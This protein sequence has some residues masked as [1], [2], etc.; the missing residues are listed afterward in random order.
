MQI[1]VNKGGRQ[2]GPYTVE[3]LRE[4]I[5]QGSFSPHDLACFDGQNWV[6]VTDVPGLTLGSQLPMPP[7]APLSSAPKKIVLWSSIGGITALLAISLVVWF[8]A[9]SGKDL[10]LFYF[11]D[12]V[13]VN[14]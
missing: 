6:K 13:H 10:D 12:N 1:Y 8:L 11:V 2:Y 14:D 9:I 4:Y 7:P 5:Q 3:Q